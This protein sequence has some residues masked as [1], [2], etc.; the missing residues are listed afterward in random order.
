MDILNLY[1]ITS[2]NFILNLED[3]S[4]FILE[5]LLYISM[6]FD[7]DKIF[8]EYTKYTSYA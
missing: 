1:S 5:K 2:M 8:S 6:N 4:D 3:I 7:D